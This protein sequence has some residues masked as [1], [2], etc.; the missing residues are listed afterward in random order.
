MPPSMSEQKAPQE[1][2]SIRPATSDDIQAVLEIERQCMPAPWTEEHFRSEFDKPYSRFLVI[3]D[4]ETDSIV[5]GFIVYWLMFDECQILDVAVALQYRGMG[6]GKKLVRQAVS[7]ALKKGL[8]K[9]VLDVRV[10]NDP[11]IQLYQG[12]GFTI[13]QKRK[14]F[15]TD[16]EDAYLMELPITEDHIRF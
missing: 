11:A 3:T 13:T 10:S 9:A 5:A 4:D 14:K 2:M 16:G 8:K 1:S 7:E 15:Y 6:Y 12:I